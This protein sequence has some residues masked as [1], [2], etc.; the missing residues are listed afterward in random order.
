MR[1]L[2]FTTTFLASAC[3]A[4]GRAVDDDA[5]PQRGPTGGRLRFDAA[6]LD[7]PPMDAGTPLHPPRDA[8]R[9]SGWMPPPPRDSGQRRCTG[10][11]RSCILFS[12]SACVL[13]TGCR[14][15]DRCEGVATSCYSLFDSYS[16]TRQR[17]CYWNS[18][19]R[20]CSGSA[21]GCLL[22]DDRYECTDQRG[23]RWEEE[24]DGVATSCVL[25]T[26]AEC[27]RQEGCYLQ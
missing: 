14:R 23:C 18:S 19:R 26:E 1:A 5:G 22:M 17:G 16:C 9:D 24:C 21:W 10:V 3:V 7:E 8:G 25:L 2:V 11:A 15:D 6:M 27:L 12:S 4:D 13:Q 20:D